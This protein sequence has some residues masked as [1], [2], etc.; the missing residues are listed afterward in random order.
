MNVRKAE[1]QKQIAEAEKPVKPFNMEDAITEIFLRTL[2]RPP[3]AAELTQAKA[4]VAAAKAPL[5][6]VR[7]LLWAMLNTREFMVNH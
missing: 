1:L 5:E 7:D 6:G 3:S 2:S 4:D